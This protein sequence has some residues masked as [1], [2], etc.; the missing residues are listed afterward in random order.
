MERRDWQ[1]APEPRGGGMGLAVPRMTSAVKVLVIANVAV[2][3]FVFIFLQKPGGSVAEEQ[4]LR[5][6]A[7]S[8]KVWKD[9]FPFVPVW[10]VVTYAFLHADAMHVLMNMLGLYFLGSMLEGVIGPRRFA[11]FYFIAIVLAGFLQLMLG[12]LLSDAPILGASGGVLACVC[13]M[14]TMRPMTRIIFFIFPMTL[15]TLALIY[16]A[17]DVLNLINI[18]KG[19]GSNVASVAHLTGAAYGYAAVRA[20]WVWRDPIALFAA[21]RA[22]RAG[23]SEAESRERLDRLLAK[24][25]REGI[26]ALSGRE[27]AFLKKMSKRR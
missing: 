1:D 11:A 26:G 5:L 4:V 23:E 7:L 21:A 2:Y 22:R 25:G 27:K 9:W 15:R 19:G 3:L 24:I 20:G 6:F 12:L 13:A 16:V 17:L 8:P 18:L 14:A 10:Q